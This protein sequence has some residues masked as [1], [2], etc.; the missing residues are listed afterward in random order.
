MLHKSQIV[1]PN[2][3]NSEKDMVYCFKN[4]LCQKVLNIQ[5]GFPSKTL[6]YNIP[7]VEES[8]MSMVDTF[9][10][11]TKNDI[12]WLLKMSSNA[13]CVVEPMPIRPVKEYLDVLISPITRMFSESVS[14]VVFLRSTK[15]TL[16]KP[17]RK[18]QFRM[19]YSKQL[20]V[21]FKY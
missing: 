7:L 5:V 15:A 2:I 16:V 3:N 18:T 14:L 13:F 20:Q 21:C 9:E 17:L 11:F 1:L 10:S 4:L 8:G 6:Q 12:R 19:R